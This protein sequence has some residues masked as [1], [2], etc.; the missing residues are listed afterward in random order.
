VNSGMKANHM[1]YNY[2]TQEYESGAIDTD[3]SALRY[4]P[5][6]PARGL[7]QCHRDKGDDIITAFLKV[8]DRLV[9]ETYEES[10][11]E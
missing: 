9:G 10:H 11:D 1:F 2:D 6:G 4:L 5:E 8:S 3:E 7:Y